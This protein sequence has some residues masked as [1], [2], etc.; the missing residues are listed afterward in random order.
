MSECYSCCSKSQYL[1]ILKSIFSF[2]IL[3]I[4]D[5]ETTCFL[6]TVCITKLTNAGH[7][8]PQTYCSHCNITD[9]VS[10]HEHTH[11][12]AFSG[13]SCG[14]STKAAGSVSG[15]SGAAE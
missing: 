1:N 11:R 9:A 4:K 10:V 6:T 13:V 2:A 15:A 7:F 3:D 12:V 14:L 5:M 8:T